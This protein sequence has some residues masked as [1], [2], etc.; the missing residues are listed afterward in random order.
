MQ[1]VQ[2]SKYMCTQPNSTQLNVYLP[3]RESIGTT[4]Q[5]QMAGCQRCLSLSKPATHGYNNVITTHI[6]ARQRKKRNKQN[7]CNCRCRVQKDKC[8]Y[9][10]ISRK[11]RSTTWYII[12]KVHNIQNIA[13]SFNKW[14]FSLR[15]KVYF[16]IGFFSSWG[17]SFHTLPTHWMLF[18]PVDFW[19]LLICRSLFVWCNVYEQCY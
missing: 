15:L 5:H 14:A 16:D 4:L 3:I 6:N 13:C 7:T 12:F 2:P 18:W 9:R 11:I 19:T 1:K 10:T 8:V 17:N